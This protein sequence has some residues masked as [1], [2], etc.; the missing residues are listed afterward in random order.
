ML[1][2]VKKI[3]FSNLMVPLWGPSRGQLHKRFFSGKDIL[4]KKTSAIKN[5][6]NQ[7]HN[8]GSMELQSVGYGGGVRVR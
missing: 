8:P 1:F 4:R 7:R 5:S 6:K 2:K 3:C